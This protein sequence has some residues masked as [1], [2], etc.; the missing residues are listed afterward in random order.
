MAARSAISVRKT[1]ILISDLRL[2]PS[3]AAHGR[4]LFQY[5]ASLVLYRLSLGF[6][7]K[8]SQA[9]DVQ[10]IGVAYRVHVGPPGLGNFA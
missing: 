8:G 1:V 7:G 5:G 3:L 9:R 6:G 4:Q 10:R 2:V